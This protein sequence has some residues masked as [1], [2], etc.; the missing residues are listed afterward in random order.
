MLL[1][2][3]SLSKL[4]TSKATQFYGCM[5]RRDF[6]L[7]ASTLSFSQL[8]L[9]CGNAN[10]QLR[11]RL[12][13]ETIPARLLGQFQR[14]LS[15]PTQLDFALDTQ[16]LQIF[17]RLQTWQK[18]PEKPG[19]FGVSLP[20]SQPQTPTVS[21]LATLGDYWLT[22]AI[23]QGL[24]QPLNPAQLPSWG[25][26]PE[27]WQTIVQRDSQGLLDPAG[28]VW[29]APYRW[30]TTVMVFRQDKFKD[31]G[32]I[33]QDWSD[34]WRPELRDRIS[35]PDQAR[36]VIGLTLKSLGKSYNTEDLSTVSQLPERLQQL[37]QQVKLYS[38]DA[39]LQP[40]LSGD[41]W[42]AVGWSA[43][44]WSVARSD[45][46]LGITIPRS[47][48][49]L[50]ADVWV[51]PKRP[52]GNNQSPE[53]TKLQNQWIDFCWQLPAATEISLYS[54]AASPV[55]VE[56]DRAA[57][58]E[59]FQQ[60]PILLPTQDVLTASEFLHPLPEKTAQTYQKL[61]ETIRG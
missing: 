61:W 19:I 52:A 15:Q 43:E 41:T 51:Q 2:F 8:L 50:W 37:H 4:P 60:N 38:S 55:F 34:L 58:P 24:I 29:G 28:A 6:L 27:K 39:Y 56:S 46:N 48:T 9:S 1:K 45:R 57:L 36:E 33:P 18:P 22:A 26:L 13:K 10:P 11:V 21:D 30:G 42:L 44:A 40:L 17:R 20:F 3:C 7:G 23:R 59:F 12:L 25:K 32:W 35:L 49:A 53:T 31:L 5:K 14:T 16:L 54:R 47:G